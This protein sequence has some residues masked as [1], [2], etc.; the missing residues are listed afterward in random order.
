MTAPKHSAL[1]STLEET[2]DFIYEV[3]SIADATV[4]A[5]QLWPALARIEAMEAS[6]AHWK[7]RCRLASAEVG[8][9]A[10]QLAEARKAAIKE[11]KAIAEQMTHKHAS[12]T[13]DA[14]TCGTWNHGVRII[15]KLELL[16]AALPKD[17]SAGSGS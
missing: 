2:I 17:P 9:L 14:Y 5:E 16:L 8:K 4:K 10:A 13:G 3:R 11:C 7:D 15:G 6:E 1:P 12:P